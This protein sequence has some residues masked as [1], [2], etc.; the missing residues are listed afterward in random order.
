MKLFLSIIENVIEGVLAWKV[1]V[2]FFID[3]SKTEVGNWA[4]LG[5]ISILFIIIF[6]EYISY[7]K[8]ECAWIVSKLIDSKLK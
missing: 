6:C 4:Y 3:L 8:N 1:M 7:K 2:P 5:F